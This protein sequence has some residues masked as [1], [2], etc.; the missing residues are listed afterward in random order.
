M[1]GRSANKAGAPAPVPL[2]P[3]HMRLRTFALL[4]GVP[5]L[6]M[7]ALIVGLQI[8]ED[9]L[10]QSVRSDPQTSADGHRRKRRSRRG[11]GARSAPQAHRPVQ[12]RRS[13]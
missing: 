2:E 7:G 13:W 8:G 1:A 6:L 4:L 5:L 12:R 3:P 9:E 10:G 11:R